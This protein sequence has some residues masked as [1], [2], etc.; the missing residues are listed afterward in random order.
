MSPYYLQGAAIGHL[1][2]ILRIATVLRDSWDRSDEWSQEQIGTLAE[3][4]YKMVDLLDQFVGRPE[5]HG[6]Y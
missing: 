1:D 5:A 6:P 2:N 3:V 4:D